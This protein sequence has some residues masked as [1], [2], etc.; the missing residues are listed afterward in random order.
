M[1]AVAVVLFI[2]ARKIWWHQTL[3]MMAAGVIGSFVGAR[4]AKRINPRYIR[5]AVSVISGGITVAFFLRR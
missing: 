3:V 5:S 2:I 1:N 4:S